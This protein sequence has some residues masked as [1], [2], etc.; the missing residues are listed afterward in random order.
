M[1]EFHLQMTCDN[2]AF[3]E[4]GPEIARIL[5]KLARHVSSGFFD[6]DCGILM[7]E[8]GNAVGSWDWSG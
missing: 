1:A 2:A 5:E 3:E 4:P 7:D 8:N 6:T